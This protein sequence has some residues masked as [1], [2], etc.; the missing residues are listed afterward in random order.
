MRKF[1]PGDFVIDPI[2]RIGMINVVHNGVHKAGIQY[3]TDGPFGTYPLR[4]LRWA[5]AE[6]IARAGYDGVGHNP[7][8]GRG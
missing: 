6:E 7:P 8:P 3:G 2:G 4:T 5:T 1:E